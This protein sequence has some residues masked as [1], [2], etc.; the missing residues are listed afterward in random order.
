MIVLNTLKGKGVSFI[1]NV[2]DKNHSM[3]ITK[4]DLEK[5]LEELK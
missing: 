4:E 1:E 5:A 2:P 3:P